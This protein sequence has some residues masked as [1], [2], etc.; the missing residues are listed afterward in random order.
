MNYAVETRGLSKVFGKTQALRDV[1]IALEENKIYG[2]LGRNGAGKSTLIKLLTAQL[3]PTAGEIK[4]FGETPYENA[5]VLSQICVIKESGTFLKEMKARD[6][7]KIAADYYPN[8]DQSLA[9]RMVQHFKLNLRKSYK[10]LSLGMKSQLGMIVGIASRAPLTIFDEPYIGLD[11]PARQFFYDL[12]LDEYTAHPR[13]FILATH[14]IDEVANLFEEVIILAGG[15]VKL[16][17][18]ADR[19]KEK[20]L[21]ISGPPEEV[22]SKVAGKQVIYRN[23]LGKTLVVGLYDQLSPAEIRELKAAGLEVSAMPL[24]KLFIYL[25][26]ERGEGDV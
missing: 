2:L 17:D 18:E 11:A 24:Q 8:W 1:N 10:S 12:L 16:H 15:T 6:A 26:A 4:I 5:R 20:S 7:L 14:L 21:F 3:F 19:I 23:T 25:T 9:D 22:E 13:T